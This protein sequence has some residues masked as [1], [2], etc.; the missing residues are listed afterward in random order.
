MQSHAKFVR[1]APPRLARVACSRGFPYRR[2][3][4]PVYAHTKVTKTE[5]G[6]GHR[7]GAVRNF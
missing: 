3:L 2:V 5:E 4:V 7:G 6:L 1:I